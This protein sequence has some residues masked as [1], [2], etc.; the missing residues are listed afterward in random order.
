MKK[1]SDLPRNLYRR[2]KIAEWRRRKQLPRPRYE[3]LVTIVCVV[4]FIVALLLRQYD[5]VAAFF[6]GGLA[7]LIASSII[8]WVKG[9]KGEGQHLGGRLIALFMVG[10]LPLTAIAAASYSTLFAHLS[11]E[12]SAD[13]YLKANSEGVGRNVDHFV[14]LHEKGHLRAHDKDGVAHYQVSNVLAYA[15]YRTPLLAKSLLGEISI[16]DAKRHET[17]HTIGNLQ[18]WSVFHEF[19]PFHERPDGRHPVIPE[20]ATHP[21]IFGISCLE[22]EDGD[23]FVN[24]MILSSPSNESDRPDFVPNPELEGLPE[25]PH[26]GKIAMPYPFFKFDATTLDFMAPLEDVCRDLKPSAEVAE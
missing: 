17:W 11:E 5:V 9:R 21:F 7:I 26:L 16:E 25:W 23:I 19:I 15:V 3:R 1:L 4:G 13:A 22:N 12:L 14:D 24:P 8:L 20:N 2:A 10:I 6:Y 18:H